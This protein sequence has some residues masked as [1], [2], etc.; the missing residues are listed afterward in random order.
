[1]NRPWEVEFHGG[2]FWNAGG[3]GG[4]AAALP[5]GT[6]FNS[7]LTGTPTLSVPSYMFG[8]GAALVNTIVGAGTSADAQLAVFEAH[9]E[10][11]REAALRA[12]TDWIA[13]ATLQ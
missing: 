4:Q 3:E 8:D 12:V 13:S 1:M 6:P 5:S 9:P 11:S 7:F 2:G 10:Q